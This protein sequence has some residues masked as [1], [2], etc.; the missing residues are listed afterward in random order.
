MDDV[1]SISRAESGKLE[2][3][4]TPL[5]F[6]E[7]CQNLIEE[8]QFGFAKNHHIELLLKGFVPEKDCNICYLDEKCLR[9][10]LINLL[11]N[12]TKYSAV[13]SLIQLSLDC[14]EQQ[15]I[16]QISDQGIGIPLE[17]QSLLFEPF[18]RANNVH[19]IPGTGLGLK[20]VQTYVTLHKGKVEFI[21]EEGEGTTFTVTLPRYKN[22]Q[23]YG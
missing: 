4:P 2:F 23:S 7:F 3:N 18:Y 14:Q 20:I 16:F 13:D 15:I 19:T 11:S 5:D 17:D 8:I 10:I 6:V 22:L 9:H 21:S 1:L 12:A